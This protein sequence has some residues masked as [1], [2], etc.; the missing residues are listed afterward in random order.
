MNKYLIE[1][2][3]IIEKLNI[4]Y[5]TT[6]VKEYC[7]ILTVFRGFFIFLLIEINLYI[8]YINICKYILGNELKLSDIIVDILFKI[9]LN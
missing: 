7:V 5:Y 3:H 9:S 1:N 4:L 6:Y 2:I 8:L